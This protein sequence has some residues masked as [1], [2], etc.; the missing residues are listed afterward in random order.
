MIPDLNIKDYYL[1][2]IKKA[3]DDSRRYKNL[4]ETI[5]QSKEDLYNYINKNKVIIKNNYNIN[6]DDFKEEWVNKE[7]ISSRPLHQRVLKLINDNKADNRLLIIQLHK[8]CN[9]LY[10]E[11]KYTKSYNNCETRKNI[12]FNTYR[13]YITIYFNKVHQY[14]LEGYGYK[15]QYGIGTYCLNYWKL[16]ANKMKNKSI[17]DFAATNA[18]KKELLSQ[19]KKLY[20]DIEAAWY[21]ARNIPYDGID[22]RIYK[23]NDYFYEF[24]FIKSNIFRSSNLEYKHT[25]YVASKYRGMSYIDMAEKL[26]NNIEDI[27]NLQVDI[28]YKLNILLY[29]DPTKYLNFI[30]N[31][32]QCKYKRGAHNS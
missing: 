8:Y 15:F 7:F 4:L 11:Y 22:Y 18:R 2:F 24:T 14:I 25:E 26:C 6:L 17:I 19:G 13:K 10:L 12:K 28:K 31:A 3:N 16:D 20:N 9:N 21:K 32:E 5:L 27:Y 23:Q 29:K 30:R 1:H